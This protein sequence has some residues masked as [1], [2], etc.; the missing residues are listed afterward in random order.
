MERK[1]LAIIV[2]E[3]M[4]RCWCGRCRLSMWSGSLE[5]ILR[6]VQKRICQKLIS[7]EDRIGQ[8]QD[9]DG[10]TA[11]LKLRMLEQT[12]YGEPVG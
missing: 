12:T 2:A 3:G 4:R 10:S 8:G 7:R 1:W 5:G 6:K 9:R 11:D